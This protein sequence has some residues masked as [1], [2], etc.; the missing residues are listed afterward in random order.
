LSAAS[1]V[2]VYSKRFRKKIINLRIYY[3]LQISLL[4]LAGYYK[5]D[6]LHPPSGRGCVKKQI[7][8]S[9]KR[10][11]STNAQQVDSCQKIPNTAT[12]DP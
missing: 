1:F 5:V 12:L 6:L 3:F 4:Q 7:N 10:V 2:K 11:Y 8:L 9:S